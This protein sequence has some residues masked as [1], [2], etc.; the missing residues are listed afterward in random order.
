MKH[1][2]NRDSKGLKVKRFEDVDYL[3]KRIAEESPKSGV[4]NRN[5]RY[6]K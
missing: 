6:I 4:T 2:K 5:F 1:K 3:E